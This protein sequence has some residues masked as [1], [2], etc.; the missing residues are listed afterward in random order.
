MSID[1]FPGLS[2]VIETGRA[3]VTEAKGLCADFGLDLRS[4]LSNGPMR[5]EGIAKRI[6]GRVIGQFAAP[7]ILP[8]RTP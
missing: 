2:L 7:E 1:T 5:F 4:G 6:V 8:R 3:L